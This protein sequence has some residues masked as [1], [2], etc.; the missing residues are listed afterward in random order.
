MR[1][2]ALAM[3]AVFTFAISL[4]V[5]PAKAQ[6]GESMAIEVPFAFRVGDKTLPAGKYLVGRLSSSSSCIVVRNAKHGPSA[7]ALTA[8]SLQSNEKHNVA[9]VVFKEIG[10]VFFLAEVWPQ[11]GGSGVEMSKTDDERD[12]AK[13]GT[14]AQLVAVLAR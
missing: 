1:S 8:G 11:G 2:Y 10:G 5:S 9:R 4:A 13:A 14:K 6:Q 7:G 3:I 12:L